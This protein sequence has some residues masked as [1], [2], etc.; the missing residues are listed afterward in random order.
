MPKLFH[1]IDPLFFF[2]IKAS[3]V[4][5]EVR[6]ATDMSP[7]NE[8]VAGCLFFLYKNNIQITQLYTLQ[9]QDFL[10]GLTKV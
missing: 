3:R 4:S 9:T 1:G 6:Y 7:I 5:S 2:T 10:K 8:N